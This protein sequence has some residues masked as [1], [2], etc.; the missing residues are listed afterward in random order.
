MD[1]TGLHRLPQDYLDFA[2]GRIAHCFTG[3]GLISPLTCY[4][5][6]GVDK[7]RCL[8][9]WDDE[10]TC[11]KYGSNSEITI[12]LLSEPNESHDNIYSYNILHIGS[13]LILGTFV[14]LR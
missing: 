8:L 13:I 5:A 6:C 11:E 1:H 10:D 14:L 3:G 4:D 2:M 12:V 7:K 9:H